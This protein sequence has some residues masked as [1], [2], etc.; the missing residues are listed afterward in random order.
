MATIVRYSKNDEL[1]ILLGTGHG[2]FQSTR[3]GFLGGNLFPNTDEGR[4]SKVA[5][6]DDEGRI[7]W[8]LSDELTVVS[9]DDEAPSSRLERARSAWK[10]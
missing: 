5:V 10:R 7:F 1:Y 8:G 3:P 2:M 6:C 9:V 4:E